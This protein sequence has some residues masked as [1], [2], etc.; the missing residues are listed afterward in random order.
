MQEIRQQIYREER[1]LFGARDL[2]I[3]DCVFDAG[4]SPLKESAG[5][6]LSGA[7]FRW[8]YPLWYADRVL[9]EDCVF[10]DTARAGIW[11]SREIELRRTVIEAPKTFRR[12]RS[13]TLTD[14]SLPHAEETLWSCENVVMKNLSVTGDYF[15]M[16][17][18]GLT[19]DGLTLDGRYAFDGVK[20]VTV[21]NAR[22]LTKDAFWNSENVTIEDSFIAGEYLGWNSRNLTLVNCTVESLQGLCYID[23]LTLKNTKL[24]NTTLAFEYSTVDAEIPSRVD[25]VLNPS[26]GVIRA[27]EI[28]DLILEKDR[29]D[30]ARTEIRCGRIEKRSDKLIW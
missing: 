5:L 21:R 1:A 24:L 16:N 15:A 23:G 27:G 26:A 17:C 7:L 8:K 13:L 19:V 6:E 11:Y 14:V 30:P 10:F 9:A 2:R 22:L 20:D 3:V 12:C 28:G 25:S 29:V 4:E 18:S